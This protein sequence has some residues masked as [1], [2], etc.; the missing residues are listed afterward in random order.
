MRS[1]APSS[2]NEQHT[3][4]AR[5]P[6]RA[7]VTRARHALARYRHAL[8]EDFAF[9]R[10]A[11]AKYL[12]D[13]IGADTWPKEA[14]KRIGLQMMVAIRT[15]HLFRDVGFL[16]GA[17][18]TSRLIRHVYGAEVHWNSCWEPGINIVHGN[19]LV[20]GAGAHIHTGCLLLHNVTLGD[21]YDASSD[22]IGGPTLRA[23]VHV[24]PNSCLLGPIEIGEH[25]K[26]MAGSTL[27]HSV[28]A[29][30][31]VRPAEVVVSSRAGFRT[32]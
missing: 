20:V 30:S 28:P 14:V 23:N 7:G 18:A 17:Q 10:Q 21:A 16:P 3:R 4:Q 9:M 2:V 31:L 11:R 6:S 24:G 29:G 12:N 13:H 25:S 8:Q 22:L 15:M 1:S 5:A 32:H 27:D 26:I 19:G